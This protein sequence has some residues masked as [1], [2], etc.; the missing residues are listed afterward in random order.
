[1]HDGLERQPS[2]C[3]REVHRAG[4]RDGRE[5]TAEQRCQQAHCG[6]EHQ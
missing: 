2:R 1:L 4:Q 5:Q 6:D 3:G